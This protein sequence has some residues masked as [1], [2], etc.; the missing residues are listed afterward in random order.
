MKKNI[1]KGVLL[2]CGLAFLVGMLKWFCSSQLLS[3]GQIRGFAI[4]LLCIG[5]VGYFVAR[6]AA[7]RVQSRR[8]AG[9]P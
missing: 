1:A 5:V 3:E 6:S 9:H 7:R 4:G 8:T 2:F